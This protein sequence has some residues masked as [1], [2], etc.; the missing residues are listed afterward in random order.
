MLKLHMIIV[1]HDPIVHDLLGL[2]TKGK[3]ACPVCSPKMKSCH[4]RTLGKK[5]FEEFRYFLH[6][7]HRY[8][9]VKKHRF[10]GKEETSSRPRRMTPHLWKLEYDQLN[11]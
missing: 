4:L 1:Q 11:R 2:Q 3:F 6:N 10:K 8:Q 5:V 7:N 9:I